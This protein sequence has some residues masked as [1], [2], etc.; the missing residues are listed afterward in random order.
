M[1][2]RYQCH[3][4]YYK[5]KNDEVE[6]IWS[7]TWTVLCYIL[8]YEL[9]QAKRGLMVISKNFVRYISAIDYYEGI[10]WFC[11]DT[12]ENKMLQYF[13]ETSES[14]IGYF[15]LW[16]HIL[17]HLRHLLALCW[18]SHKPPF[19]L[20]QLIYLYWTIS[21]KTHK[22]CLCFQHA[23]HDHTI[24]LICNHTSWMDVVTPTDRPYS[25]RNRCVIELVCGV[26]CVVTLPF[27]HFC[28]CRGFCHRTESDILLFVCMWSWIDI[29]TIH[30]PSRAV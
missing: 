26:V 14:H 17:R 4:W 9:H 16:R 12:F 21:K 25:V 13:T 28:W 2:F 6:R 19:R 27:L 23:K 1:Y 11:A 22:S 5:Q 24:Y 20:A 10:Y 29:L 8:E 30:F 3:H 18:K 15:Q 7:F